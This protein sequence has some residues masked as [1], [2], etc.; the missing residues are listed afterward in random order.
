MLEIICFGALALTTNLCASP[1]VNLTASN[2]IELNTTATEVYLAGR[3]YESDYTREAERIKERQDLR[4]YRNSDS[5]RY[6]IYRNVDLGDG[7]CID[8]NGR[9]HRNPDEECL[10]RRGRDRIYRTPQRRYERRDRIYR[11]PNYRR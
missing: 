4:N 1:G 9:I 3:P 7:G 8:R 6:R 11:E 2:A 5:R 10:E